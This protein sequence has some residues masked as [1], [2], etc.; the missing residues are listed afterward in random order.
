ML[1]LQ[2]PRNSVPACNGLIGRRTDDHLH[3]AVN[4]SKLQDWPPVVSYRNETMPGYRPRTNCGLS[5]S[6][7]VLEY[8]S[9]KLVSAE[10]RTLN[11]GASRG[12][13]MEHWAF[14]VGGAFPETHQ[15]RTQPASITTCFSKQE[16]THDAHEINHHKHLI[17]F[18]NW[19]NF[20]T[21]TLSWH[22]FH[23]PADQES[24]FSGV[25]IELRQ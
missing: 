23:W 17:F 12:Y 8:S 24:R 20:A 18:V 21:R 7:A 5:A 9:P 10:T 16:P 4:S 19:S 22:S 14:K 13:S 3:K 6:S 1:D 11:A 15:H 25:R 2:A